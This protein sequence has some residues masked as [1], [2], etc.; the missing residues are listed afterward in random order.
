MARIRAEP[1]EY[2]AVSLA[3]SRLK[4]GEV[5]VRFIAGDETSTAISG[6]N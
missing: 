3:V 5:R 2:P 4:S 6:T 1:P